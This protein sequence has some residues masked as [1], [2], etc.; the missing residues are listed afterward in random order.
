MNMSTANMLTM[1][2]LWGNNGT[3]KVTS[4]EL[5]SLSLTIPHD[6]HRGGGLALLKLTPNM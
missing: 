2:D 5:H 4:S 3:K 1:E 6:H